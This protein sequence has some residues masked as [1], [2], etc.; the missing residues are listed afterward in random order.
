MARENV[1]GDGLTD[2]LIGAYR[3]SDSA[4]HAGKAYL[5]LGHEEGYSG[6]Y[7]LS[8][9]HGSYQG[10]YAGDTAGFAV[11]GIGDINSDGYQDFAV[12]AH[13]REHGKG[14]VYVFYGGNDPYSPVPTVTPSATPTPIVPP[15]EPL[16]VTSLSPAPG[17]ALD[18][19]PQSIVANFNRAFDPDTVNRETFELVRSGGDGVFGNGNDVEISPFSVTTSGGTIARMNISG[20]EIPSDVYRVTLK[21]GAEAGSA[22]SFDGVDD[23]VDLPDNLIH[24]STVLTLEARFKTTSTGVILGYQDHKYP[25]LN[26][27]FVPCI[28]VGTDGKLQAVFWDD[29]HV[30]GPRPVMG[31]QSDEPVDDGEWHHVAL[32]GNGN[33]QKAYLDGELIG[34]RNAQILHWDMIYNQIGMGQTR[35]WAQ[36]NGDW[37]PFK[38]QID[39][40]RLWNVARS[41]QAI[42]EDMDSEL[43]GNEANLVGCWTFGEGD[44]QVLGDIS[45]NGHDGQLGS[46]IRTRCER[47]FLDRR[48][49]QRNRRSVWDAFGWRIHV[50]FPLGR[51]NA[52]RRFCGGIHDLPERSPNRPHCQDHSRGADYAGGFDLHGQRE[53]GPGWRPGQLCIPVVSEWERTERDLVRI[54]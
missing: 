9:P 52:G 2:F 14:Y 34:E 51:R 47:P 5:Y 35:F 27:D 38:G 8:F 31:I 15:S 20:S 32:V 46:F 41:Q 21:S 17:S 3:S 44:G 36:V 45:P 23:Y 54:E 43:N 53:R 19:A 24:A 16:N 40:M 39:E 4:Y 28:F 12:G 48:V 7:D 26:G 42:Q 22:L 25:A 49:G 33:S 29:D 1:N 30:D 18:S 6:E 11:S 37:F 50:E 10:E 13:G